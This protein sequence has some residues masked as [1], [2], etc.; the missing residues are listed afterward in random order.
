MN[1]TIETTENK[2][3]HGACIGGA[4]DEVQLLLALADEVETAKADL[5]IKQTALRMLTQD[6]LRDNPNL[7]TMRFLSKEAR[8]VDVTITLPIKKLTQKLHEIF[9]GLPDETREALV[10]TKRKM[11]TSYTPR[12]TT[13][14]LVEALIQKAIASSNKVPEHLLLLQAHVAP[15]TSV[16]LSPTSKLP[17]A[18]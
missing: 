14:D 2:G 9:K 16:K 1:L 7:T 17:W 11:I 5:T 18:K 15:V 3:K 8:A 12:K 4:E 13:R 10:D 6:V